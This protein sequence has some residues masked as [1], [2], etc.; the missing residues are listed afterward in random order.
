MTKKD[1]LLGDT[2]NPLGDRV[3]EI[4]RKLKEKNPERMALNTGAIY[5]PLGETSGK[6]KLA[7]WSREVT[8][9]FPD[10][11]GIYT[12]TGES[13]NTFELTMLAYYFDVSDGTPLS[14][15]WIAFNQIPGGMFYAQAFQG[16]TGNEL[17]KAFGNDSD[18]FME[19][20]ALLAGR[21]E[22]FG[23]FA[24]SYQ[25]LPRVPIMVVCWLGDEDFPPSYRILFDSNAHHHL[26]TDAYAILGSNLTRRLIKVKS[27]NKNKDG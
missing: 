25:I 19:A 4:R 23:N 13:I 6:F 15:E 27:S 14:G 5:T 16:Y 21:R 26:V 11:T 9:R 22:F 17:A 7:F 24:Y 1:W 3:D 8:I 12:G 18:A 10:F 20:N 2:P